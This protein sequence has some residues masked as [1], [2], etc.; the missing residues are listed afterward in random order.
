ML[1]NDKDIEV[2]LLKEDNKEVIEKCIISFPKT[3]LFNHSENKNENIKKIFD[4]NSS[5][6]V[7]DVHYDEK[8]KTYKVNHMNILP[9]MTIEELKYIIASIL[10]TEIT[11]IVKIFS[12]WTVDK[13]LQDDNDENNST[14]NENKTLTENEKTNWT[15]LNEN[16][17]DYSVFDNNTSIGYRKYFV[18]VIKRNYT[19]NTSYDYKFYENYLNICR[20]IIS[21]PFYDK[22][23]RE[24]ILKNKACQNLE[25]FLVYPEEKVIDTIDIVKLFNITNISQTL[26][27]VLIHDTSLT[28]FND[29]DREVQ[30]VKHSNNLTE[31]FKNTFSRFNCCSVYIVNEIFPSIVLSRIEFY[32]TGL[33]K[34]C[35][36]IKDPELQWETIREVMAKYFQNNFWKMFEKLHVDEC[37]YNF[38]FDIH[39]LI[40]IYG[41]YSFIFNLDSVKSKKFT[42][43]VEISNQ[44][45]PTMVYKT[46]TS[47]FLNTYSIQSLESF[48]NYYYARTYRTM[49]TDTT[50]RSDV[51][52]H[53]HIQVLDEENAVIYFTK[54]YSL[55]DLV[56]NSILFLS[57]FGL[58]S[59]SNDKEEN[60][61]ANLPPEKQIEKIRKKYQKIPTKKGIKKLNEIDPILFGT[62]IINDDEI[63]P[64]SALAQ[65]KE[66]RVVSIT[67]NEYEIIHETQP[68]YVI[69]IKNQSQSSQRLYL[70][71]PWEK[72]PYLNFHH[73]HN[74][75]CIPKCTTAITKKTQ[76]LYCNN[77]LEAKGFR[78]DF[79]GDSS[80]MVVYYSPLLLP[81][82]R[83]FPPDEL[84]V[85]CE[86][87]LL[88]K[89]PP[90]TDLLTF[91]RENYNTL[92]CVILR[93]NIDK[94]Y[95]LQTE[96]SFRDSTNYTL[97]IQSEMDGNYYN[98]IDDDGKPFIISE[99]KEF[100]KFLKVIQ[101]QNNIGWDVFNYIDGIFSLGVSK[102]YKENT[103]KNVLLKLIEKFNIKFVSNPQLSE[104]IGIIYKKIFLT[105]PPIKYDKNVFEL[106]LINVNTA[107]SSSSLPSLKLFSPRYITKYFVGFENEETNDNNSLTIERKVYA[108]EYK[109]IIV[110]VSPTL[111][112]HDDNLSV[113]PI[114]LFDNEA[115]ENYYKFITSKKIF[116]NYFTDTQQE[117]LIKKLI[118]VYLFIYYNNFSL[119]DGVE[120]SPENIPTIIE[121][122]TD[123]KFFNKQLSWKLSK[124]N[125]KDFENVFNK[126]F[127]N[128]SQNNIV[129][130]FYRIL[131]ENLNIY[132]G[133]NTTITSKIITNNTM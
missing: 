93:N 83:C 101:T 17:L 77:Q 106:D 115:Y 3:F 71:C 88:L 62:R 52:S 6:Y 36:M 116:I 96:V 78:T 33:I 49:S 94:Q 44:N 113:K 64:Y 68:E 133:K 51:L 79:N 10:Q 110:L 122:K 81:G 65:K 35:F 67:K 27:K 29:E 19:V 132:H 82:R 40:P 118:S 20:Y 21:T 58:N 25:I 23:T 100:M 76:Y 15:H 72:F 112:I 89:L 41:A 5:G 130:I 59:S 127:A 86:N 102:L 80:K 7:Q 126:Y 14:E 124:I 117:T 120:F 74:Q 70:F 121:D 38:K 37:V 87:Y 104:I 73:Y 11:N 114:I 108:I 60:N 45:I 9:W 46:N 26:K 16:L 56:M 39:K 75:L 107:L 43:F 53:S 97:I 98:V 2:Y 119:K 47:I 12:L 4:K 1:I 131:Q 129:D 8:T 18:Y 22:I 55:D 32:K 50:I 13:V 28:E 90:G 63:R 128:L 84:S 85:V 105:I 92:P 91:C 103:F 48:Y 54:I 99:H 109:G 24:D 34:C 61:L 95:I 123:I 31:P 42:N 66:Q 30:Y 57:M 111:E 69:N 125:K